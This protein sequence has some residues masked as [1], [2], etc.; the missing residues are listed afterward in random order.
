MEPVALSAE[1]QTFAYAERMTQLVARIDDELLD[2]VDDLVAE[3]HVASRSE[4][5]RVALKDLVERRRR[6]R[7]AQEIIAGY[8]K[9]PQTD[10][11]I[12]WVDAATVAMIGEEPW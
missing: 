11:E 7:T 8:A 12:G 6:E 2:A 1:R 9:H 3:G 4:A 10:A 5:V